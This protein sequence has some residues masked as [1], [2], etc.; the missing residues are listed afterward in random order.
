MDLEEVFGTNEDGSLKS[1]VVQDLIDGRITNDVLLLAHC[2]ML[3]V[4]PL[5]D[6][7]YSQA[8]LDDTG[9]YRLAFQL[10]TWALK[11]LSFH[12]REGR[13]YWELAN[14]NTER[15][16]ALGKM[17]NTIVLMA[18][19]GASG[20]DLEAMFKGEYE[21]LKTT[22]FNFL[23]NL[24][25][26]IFMSQYSFDK[27]YDGKSTITEVLQKQFT[28]AALSLASTIEEDVSFFYR[29]RSNTIRNNDP[30]EKYGYKTTGRLPFGSLYYDGAQGV[31]ILKN[32][33]K[34]ARG[35]K[36]IYKIL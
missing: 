21:G 14:N 12:F 18:I 25:S 27:V 3:D 23:D 1:N 13:K 24:L 20:D 29:W 15:L 16:Y 22:A 2:K 32:Y 8:Y 17:S 31:P 33:L 19:A 28:P 34:G 9:A 35:R 26:M 6:S 10:K 4:Q 5:K 30:S 7:E 36:N 11:N